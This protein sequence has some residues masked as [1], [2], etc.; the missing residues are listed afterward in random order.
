MNALVIL[1]IFING[2]WLNVVQQPP[3]NDLFVSNQ[4]GVVTQYHLAAE[5][6]AYGLLAHSG[7]A[8]KEFRKLDLGEAVS[9]QFEDGTTE[10]YTV[11]EIAYYQRSGYDY[12]D[13]TANEVRSF[14]DMMERFYMNG[15]KLVF[16]TC[17]GQNGLVFVTAASG[18]A[19][20]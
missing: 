13:A 4:R 9:A 17:V 8:G 10:D 2:L 6:G 7:L 5:F 14:A 20:P 3:D 19:M 15:N 11:T 1:A 16:Q 18:T 12:I